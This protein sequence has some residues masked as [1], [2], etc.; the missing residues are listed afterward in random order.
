M[1]EFNFEGSMDELQS[2]VDKLEKG[3]LTLDESVDLFKRGV[4]LSKLCTKKLDYVEKQ[5]TILTE[6]GEEDENA[7]EQIFEIDG[8]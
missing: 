4:D 7:D 8:D 2:I 1:K 6:D 3:D 5:I